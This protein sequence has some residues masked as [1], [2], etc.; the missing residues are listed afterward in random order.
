MTKELLR[1]QYREK[2]LALTG[3]ERSKLDDLVLI[4]FQQ[5]KI[6]VEI[7]KLLS[8]WPLQERGEP[9]SFLITDFLAFRLPGLE[10]AYP[11]SD[12][13][14]QTMLAMGV[15]ENTEFVLGNY[16]IAQPKNGLLWDPAEIDL[17]LVPLLAFDQKG[18]RLGYGKGFYDRFLPACRPDCLLVGVSHFPPEPQLPG[19]DQFDVPL[20]ACITPEMIYEF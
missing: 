20:H 11:V 18:N 3:S 19:I 12:Y 13:S 10:L 6:P 14:A 15:D 4:R 9:S 1:Q 8:Y 17:V 2:R 7:S 16:G 5:W